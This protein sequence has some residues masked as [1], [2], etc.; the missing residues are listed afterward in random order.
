MEN[1]RERFSANIQEGRF[2]HSRFG[3]AS[4][5]NATREQTFSRDGLFHLGKQE[6]GYI[7]GHAVLNRRLL[8]L[9]F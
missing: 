2:P 4:R 1:R 6:S 7:G 8:I 5:S 9:E 3:K